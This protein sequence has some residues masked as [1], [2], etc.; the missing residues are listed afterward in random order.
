MN[1]YR[2][3]LVVV[4][5]VMCSACAKASSSKVGHEPVIEDAEEFTP[6]KN[7]FE[8]S[9]PGANPFGR[10][11]DELRWALD[12]AKVPVLDHERIIKTIL[13]N[14]IRNA[15]TFW[16]IS[17]G[18]ELG[19]MVFGIKKR[20]IKHGVVARVS[21]WKKGVT[22]DALVWYVPSTS[23][24]LWQVIL[25]KVCNNWSFRY[26]PYAGHCSNFEML[27]CSNCA[28][29]KAPLSFGSDSA[30]EIGTMPIR[31]NPDYVRDVL[32]APENE[33]FGRAYE[34]WLAGKYDGT[35]T[36]GRLRVMVGGKLRFDSGMRE[37]GPQ[38]RFALSSVEVKEIVAKNLEVSI[39]FTHDGYI[40]N[41]VPYAEPFTI[42][43]KKGEVLQAFRAGKR[44]FGLLVGVGHG[45]NAVTVKYDPK[46]PPATPIGR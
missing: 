44:S 43:T 46:G 9:K 24:G 14:N 15:G 39:S 45:H 10:T 32:G 27:S 40:I 25:P 37:F 29:Q 36:Q 26:I 18:A 6:Y 12:A 21:K 28:S 7:G 16:K 11:L 1:I 13:S 41:G 38:H 19:S 42:A 35:V 31:V 33:R 34:G 5:L 22:H 30:F 17:E 3:C 8:W 23:G 20:G 2:F 4:L